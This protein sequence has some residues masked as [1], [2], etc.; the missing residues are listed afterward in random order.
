M[1]GTE[2]YDINSS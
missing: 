2:I 1:T